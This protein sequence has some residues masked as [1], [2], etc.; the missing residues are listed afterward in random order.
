MSKR[1][2]NIQNELTFSNTYANDCR[3]D[4]SRPIHLEKLG[5]CFIAN[6]IGVDQY[7][8]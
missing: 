4:I 7:F 2:E 3:P 6:F 8:I 5:Y 1:K